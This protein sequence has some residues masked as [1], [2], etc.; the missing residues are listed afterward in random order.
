MS[1]PERCDHIAQY[2]AFAGGKDEP[3]LLFKEVE[4]VDVLPPSYEGDPLYV[5]RGKKRLQ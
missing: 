5:V 1:E 3:T 4:A 2:F